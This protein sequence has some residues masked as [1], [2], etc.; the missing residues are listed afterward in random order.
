M[1]TTVSTSASPSP[2]TSAADGSTASTD[3]TFSVVMPTGWKSVK[4]SPS[5]LALQAPKPQD[6]V[7]T[8]VGVTVQSPKTLPELDDVMSQ[9]AITW[10][11]QGITIKELPDRTVGGLPSRGYSFDRTAQGAKVT[12]TQYIVIFDGKIYTITL[13]SAQS[14][15]AQGTQALDGILGTWAW[16][17]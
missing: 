17:Q 14:A 6:E 4:R 9:A 15:V 16:K 11:Q 13:T 3:K 8:N 7:T 2:V 10:R 12:Q 5:V 1:A